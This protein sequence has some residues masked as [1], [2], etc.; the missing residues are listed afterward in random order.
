MRR[1]SIFTHEACK[2]NFRCGLLRVCK[3]RT[4]DPIARLLVSKYSQKA[5]ST[6][7][8]WLMIP[9][10]IIRDQHLIVYPQIINTVHSISSKV[11]FIKWRHLPFLYD[12]LLYYRLP[13]LIFALA[14][15]H[16]ACNRCTHPVYSSGYRYFWSGDTHHHSY[17]WSWEE[18]RPSNP[19]WQYMDR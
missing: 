14:V 4:G 10:Q 2:R 19:N 11:L 7:Y 6:L 8:K 12:Y 5:I 17:S 9:R 3:K 16:W 15:H 1:R 18:G 13:I